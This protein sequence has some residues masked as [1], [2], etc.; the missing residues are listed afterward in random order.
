MIDPEE[1]DPRDFPSES[2]DAQATILLKEDDKPETVDLAPLWEVIEAEEVTGVETREGQDSTFPPVVA[3]LLAEAEAVQRRLD[4]HSERL[5]RTD[6]EIRNIAETLLNQ[7]ADLDA[8]SQQAVRALQTQSA[9]RWSALEAAEEGRQKAVKRV[10]ATAEQVLQARKQD[11]YKEA[12]QSAPL[13]LRLKFVQELLPGNHALQNVLKEAAALE[14]LRRRGHDLEAWLSNYSA[15]FAEAAQALFSGGTEPLIALQLSET[16]PAEILA[17][18]T[19]HETRAALE[20]TLQ[21]L[22]IT[23]IAPAPG[24]PIL[25]EHEV[26]GEESSPQAAGRVA[27]LRRRGFH[28]QG[29]IA[30][31]AQ[32]LRAT[33]LSGGL[34]SK[35]TESGGAEASGAAA[36]AAPTF[37]DATVTAQLEREVA[38]EAPTSVSVPAQQTPPSASPPPVG[39]LEMAGGGNELPDWLRML[40]Q[41]TFGCKL[42]AVSLL[43]ERVFAL[44]E[45][46]AQIAALSEEEASSLLLQNALQPLLPLLGMRY[47]DGLPDIS[48]DWGAAFLEVQK[49]LLAWL[50][51]TL[52][53]TLVAPLRGD[54][55]DART[56]EALETRRTVHA[57]EDETVAKLERIGVVWHERPLILA[58]VVR[59]NIGGSA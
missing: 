34:T 36:Y 3:Q 22:G 15:L 26:I 27:R 40:S 57:K 7:I 38:L 37:S 29:R 19:L 14:E 16:P 6:Q 50:T 35:A 39:S 46:P 53:L 4:A 20:T 5:D 51:G 32:V 11:L 31:P 24:E 30:L 2:L 43:A 54:R 47:E 42:P 9:Q 49:P 23:W 28:L 1:I 25:A 56:M 8:Q 21:A 52:G 12:W 44:K 48:A 55:F 45:L 17:T 13:T 18:E 33:A 58:Q 41:R 59:Y 10:L